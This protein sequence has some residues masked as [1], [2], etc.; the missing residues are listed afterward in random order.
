[1]GVDPVHFGAVV[2]NDFLGDGAADAGVLQ[3]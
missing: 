1:M 2:A 3:H